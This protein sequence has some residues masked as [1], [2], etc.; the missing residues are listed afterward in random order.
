[1]KEFNKVKY[2]NEFNS[3]A[4]YRFPLMLPISCKEAI[5]EEA[6]QRGMS[7]NEFVKQAIASYVDDEELKEILLKKQK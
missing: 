7:T 5:K 4:Y 2:N 6:K 3:E 1:M